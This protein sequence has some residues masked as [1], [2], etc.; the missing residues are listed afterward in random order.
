MLAYPIFEVNDTLLPPKTQ[1]GG[2][3][4]VSISSFSAHWLLR[5]YFLEE[6]R[7]SVMMLLGTFGITR[8][9]MLIPITLTI[10]ILYTV[11]AVMEEKMLSDLFGRK[12]LAL[13]GSEELQDCPSC[14]EQDEQQT[15]C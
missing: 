15:K 6:I 7:K 4:L 8:F 2:C 5:R 11:K 10:F 12:Y 13:L 14:D 3:H 9:F 1:R